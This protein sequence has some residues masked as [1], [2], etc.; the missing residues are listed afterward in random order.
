MNV[1]ESKEVDSTRT[2]VEWSG[3]E[4]QTMRPTNRV[5]CTFLVFPTVIPFY[6]IS[7]RHVPFYSLVSSNSSNWCS[8]C[9][10][11]GGW[12]WESDGRTDW[13]DQLWDTYHLSH[14]INITYIRIFHHHDADFTAH[15]PTIL[16][17]ESYDR[18]VNRSV[19][20]LP[21]FTSSWSII[22]HIGPFLPIS[23]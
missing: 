7:S 9:I 15:W 11:F 6:S 12:I 19:A 2:L 20:P 10:W 13:T 14:A 22:L 18:R 4:C 23:L 16:A 1:S 17:I 3:V 5:I 8:L 21:S